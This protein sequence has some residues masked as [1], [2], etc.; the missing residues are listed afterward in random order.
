MKTH[1]IRFLL[2]VVTFVALTIGTAKATN[3][4]FSYTFDLT[5]GPGSSNEFE[6]YW[7]IGGAPEF[8]LVG[9]DH[10]SGVISFTG[11]ERLQFT[12][13]I[14]SAQ[15]YISLQLSVP[16]PIGLNCN[17]S[18]T[19]LGVSGQLNCLNPA[20]GGLSNGAGTTYESAFAFGLTDTTVSFS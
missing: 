16:A 17:T 2:Q 13:P 8:A 9:G 7:S 10:L 14:G 5:S 3:Y 1:S 19:F 18:L 15:E 12:D 4:T 6:R 11:A 20:L